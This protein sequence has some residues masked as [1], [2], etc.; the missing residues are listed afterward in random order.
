MSYRVEIIV[1]AGLEELARAEAQ[2]IV[3]LRLEPPRESGVIEATMRG[4]LPAL[5]ELRCAI[6]VF[7]VR[8]FTIPRPR[9]LLG[10]EHFRAVLALIETVRHLHPA[11]TFQ[12]LFLSAAGADSSVLRR[13]KHELSVRLGLAIGDE[14]GDLVLRLRPSRERNGWDLLAR[15]T[16]RPLATRPWRVCNREGALNG[17][18]AHA[19]ALLSK[20]RPNDRILNIGCGSGTLLIERLL[21]GP[22]AQAI[23]C[24]TDPEAL[25]C[26]YRN[27]AAA[28]LS[29]AVELYDW[30]ARQLPL[31]PASFNVVLADLPFGHLV[32]SHADNLTLYPA[33]LREAARVTRPGGCAVL[34]SH[35]VRLMERTLTDLP[36]W[37]KEQCLRV[38]LGGLYPRIF[39]LRRIDSA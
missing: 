3:G 32:G 27:L 15:L 21:I 26:A 7:L 8:S 16:P 25:T 4:P 6:S 9:A 23:G 22:A 2:R 12:T 39:A 17:P 10:D 18:V 19:M 38:D 31:P 34:I 29:H 33:L 14:D 35:E 11:G 30:D 37:R 36:V 28:R 5:F 20:P 24:D 1:P 13:F